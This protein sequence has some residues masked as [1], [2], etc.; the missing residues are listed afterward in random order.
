M[1][2]LPA[3]ERNEAEIA[4]ATV[5]SIGG[6]RI[7][8]ADE[9]VLAI[10]A[11]LRRLSRS[12]ISVLIQGET[13][14]GKEVI[15]HALHAWS[16]RAEAPYV[17]FNC[18]A[19]P[20]SLV[21]SELFGTV[22]GAGTDSVDRKGLM[23]SAS[24]GTVFLDE[25]SELT[26]SVQAKLLRVLEIRRVR[27]LGEVR[28]RDVDLRIVAATN[29]DLRG[30]VKRGRF[31]A[32]LLF[33]LNGAS[34]D[35]PPLRA[36]RRDVALLA[37]AF[38]EDACDRLGRPR[39]RLSEEAIH[40]L[41]G[42]PW[43]GNV[44]ELRNLMDCVAVMSTDEVIEAG[45]LQELLRASHAEEAAPEPSD[46]AQAQVMNAEICA[47]LRQRLAEITEVAKGALTLAAV[48]AAGSGP[49]QFRP[50]EEEIQSLERRRMVEALAAMAGNKTR[51]AELIGMPLTTFK[52]KYKEYGIRD[53]EFER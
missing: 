21:D 9:S 37:R 38:L 35:L 26:L 45:L 31:R 23:E 47:L 30:E 17:A 33:R 25:V 49:R 43:P 34:I 6:R 16:Q 11:R 22:R 5:L 29:R 51:A 52:G 7:L 46:E 28:E 14:T 4:A 19:L 48:L 15:A 44:R 8:A 41:E 20:E 12:D 18:A 10:F 3:D 50:I 13:G 42:Y 24:G 36:R 53:Q 1:P 39:L 40:A 27:R 32:D 2:S